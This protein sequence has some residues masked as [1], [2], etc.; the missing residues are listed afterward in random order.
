MP[1]TSFR[2]ICGT[3]PHREPVPTRQQA[4]TNAREHRAKH[5]SHVVIVKDPTGLTVAER[6]F[7]A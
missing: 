6:F 3:C 1:A 4:V 5:P 7:S 2:V